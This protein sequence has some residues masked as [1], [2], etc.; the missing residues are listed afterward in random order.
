MSF[1]KKNTDYAIRALCYMAEKENTVV[2]ATELAKELQI[3]WSLT[4]K[5]LQEIKPLTIA[6][7][8]KDT[9]AAPTTKTGG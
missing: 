1:I 5:I 7:L 3:S 9:L 2:S 6:S 8:L 4:R